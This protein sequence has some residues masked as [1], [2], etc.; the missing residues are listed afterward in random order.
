[1][2]QNWTKAKRRSVTSKRLRNPSRSTARTSFHPRTSSASSARRKSA[3]IQSYPS[4]SASSRSSSLERFGSRFFDRF[5]FFSVSVTEYPFFPSGF[6]PAPF[7]FPPRFEIILSF[8][9][10][11]TLN[12]YHSF[13]QARKIMAYKRLS[14]EKQ[15]FRS[16]V[17]RMAMRSSEFE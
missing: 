15:T 1:M 14:K 17:A 9:I 3:S 4:D 12:V 8:L 13:N 11:T 16:K 2:C 7:L 5:T 6:R 10:D